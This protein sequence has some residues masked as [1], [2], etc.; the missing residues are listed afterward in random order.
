MFRLCQLNWDI[1]KFRG[2]LIFH[3]TPPFWN[4]DYALHAFYLT[5]WI[6]VRILRKYCD[7]E[8]WE[9]SKYILKQKSWMR[10]ASE[11]FF[12]V[13][14]LHT[15]LRELIF[16]GTNFCGSQF[17]DFLRELKFA[18]LSLERKLEPF[19]ELFDLCFTHLKNFAGT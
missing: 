16:A 10:S 7:R 9:N 11:C 5:T 19:F 4:C 6:I 12:L 8:D 13:L 14:E 1:L 17:W 3:I 18:N 15:L 2:T